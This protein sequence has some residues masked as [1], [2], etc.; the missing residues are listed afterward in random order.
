MAERREL[1]TLYTFSLGEAHDDLTP[2]FVV[3]G[4]TYQDPDQMQADLDAASEVL[5]AWHI[6]SER[7]S[8]EAGLDTPAPPL[9]SWAQ[10]R[11]RYVVRG[12]P[13][14][15]R[16]LPVEFRVPAGWTPMFDWL[17]AEREAIRAELLDVASRA[18]P[19]G[20]PFVDQGAGPVRRTPA[21]VD[22]AQERYAVEI[23]VD[24]PVGGMDRM[25]AV[26]AT[27]AALAA[28]GW[29]MGEVEVSERYL[30]AAGR[31]GARSV[32]VVIR[33]TTGPLSLIGRTA[34]VG[35]DD[36]AQHEGMNRS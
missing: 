27:C 4:R 24:V 2:A 30:Q 12:E 31:S 29:Q 18:V 9:P 28:G 10:W 21:S 7:E 26:R 6:I 19:A 11:E 20:R 35:A 33:R 13:L 22:W 34:A 25:D 32:A 8:A 15:V 16:P 17:E 5:R 23:I 3:D 36:F 14:P 1:R